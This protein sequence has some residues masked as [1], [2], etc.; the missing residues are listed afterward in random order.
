MERYIIVETD[1]YGGDYPN[2][3]LVSLPCMSK[4]KAEAIANIIN[5]N[6][7]DDR[8]WK[9]EKVGY[10]LQGGFEP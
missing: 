9:V 6:L 7:R 1:N 8:Y 5:D 10:E 4:E 3:K 2:E